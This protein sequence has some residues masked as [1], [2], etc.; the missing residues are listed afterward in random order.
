MLTGPGMVQHCSF[1]GSS[2]PLGDLSL[3]ALVGRVINPT[4]QMISHQVQ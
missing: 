1:Q 3:T 4:L 2:H